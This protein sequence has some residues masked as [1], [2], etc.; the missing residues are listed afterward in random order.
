MTFD[1][2][3]SWRCHLIL[4]GAIGLLIYGDLVPWAACV[5]QDDRDHQPYFGIRVVDHQ[6]GRGV[7]MVRLRTTS[8]I[9]HWTDSNGWIAFH[10]PGLMGREV[11]FA[12]ESP[13][14]EMDADGFG[15]RGVRLKTIRGQ[16]AEVRIKRTQL[17]ERL[18]R[19]T[20]QG[21]YR[22]SELLGQAASPDIDQLNAGV[23][24]QD[25]VQAV[26]HQGSLFWL[27]GDTNLPHYPLGIFHVTAAV[28][29]LP[30]SGLDPDQGI[31]LRYFM[32][33]STGF[34]KKMLPVDDPGAVWLWGL[35][36]VPDEN[37][38][39]T[40]VAHYSRHLSL[41]NMVEH[42]IA[43]WDDRAQRFIKKVT[44]D[45]ENKWRIPQGQAFRH[46]DANGDFVY[47]AEP[48]AVT[49]VPAHVSDLLDPSK[50]QAYVWD[51]T[52]DQWLWQTD[53][54]PTSQNEE[55]A[56]IAAGQIPSTEAR[57]QLKEIMTDKP[58][59]MH[60]G[61]I[62]WNHFRQRWI[63]VACQTDRTGARSFLGEIWYAEAESITGPWH[64]AIK[65]ASHPN[66]SFYNPRHHALLDKDD[67]Q[68]IY[69]EGTYTRMFSGNPAPTPRYDYNQI[70][71]R[72]DLSRVATLI[73]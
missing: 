28:S 41:G 21:I 29:P 22:D 6:T 7:P 34:A 59:E 4:F 43:V 48:F 45:L 23:M 11:Y 69:F 26:A 71:Y 18:Y 30:E 60:R 66:Y 72:L 24:G 57:Y 39:E 68:I 73:E 1:H 58:V 31:P 50:Y 51:A 35:I 19:V 12:I 70:M 42:G 27:W 56:L 40:L 64:D 61:S 52:T 13:G 67:G 2:F 36:S 54:P 33:E 14:Y 47:F 44:F 63:M 3:V 17:A 9:D 46:R 62:N 53:L 16:A 65:V 37:N 10:E 55:T 25:S 15:F 20:G 49:R 38:A 5:E 32:D 8:N